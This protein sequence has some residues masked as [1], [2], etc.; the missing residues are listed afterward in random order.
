MLL[1]SAIF[2]S[3]GLFLLGNVSGYWA[4]AAAAVFAIGICYFWPTMLGFVSEYLP[5]TGAMGLSIMG[6][7][8]M[9]SVSFILPYIGDFYNEQ[10]QKYVDAQKLDPRIYFEP[11]KKAQLLAGAATLQYVAVLPLL[12]SIAFGFLYIYKNKKKHVHA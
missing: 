1:F 5:K 12:L 9:L 8:G 7:A 4:F 6:A 3:I 2:S 11:L 10:T